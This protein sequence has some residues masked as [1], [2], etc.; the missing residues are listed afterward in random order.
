MDKPELIEIKEAELESLLVKNPDSIEE[1]ITILGRQV[2][3]DS[4]SLDILALDIDGA[5][6]VIEVKAT[7]DDGQLD[8]GLRYYDW[9]RNNLL[10]LSHSYSNKKEQLLMQLKNLG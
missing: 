9:V 8:Q 4:G 2:K 6:V 5:L 1:Q 10:F 3:S 7:E